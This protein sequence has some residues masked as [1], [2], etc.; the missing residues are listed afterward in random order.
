MSFGPSLGAM[1]RVV[2]NTKTTNILCF[3]E[4][5]AVL[6]FILAVSLL[7]MDLG[8]A[9]VIDAM[10]THH[11]IAWEVVLFGDLSV[12]VSTLVGMPALTILAS[13]FFWCVITAP[14]SGM[15]NVDAFKELWTCINDR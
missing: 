11:K 15:V 12:R 1:S 7:L 6:V 3:F 2:A 9:I 8:A 4:R 5:N 10:T 14:V 13:G